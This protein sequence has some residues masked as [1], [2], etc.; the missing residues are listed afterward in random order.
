VKHSPS[1]QVHS[2]DG[3]PGIQILSYRALALDRSA[4]RSVMRTQRAPKQA[5][6]KIGVLGRPSLHV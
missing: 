4:A 5:Q 3:E 6:E 2:I 1:R